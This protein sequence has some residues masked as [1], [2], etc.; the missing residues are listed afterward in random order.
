M[1]TSGVGQALASEQRTS[2][3]SR[4]VI[5]GPAGALLRSPTRRSPRP[6]L[7][8]AISAAYINLS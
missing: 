8:N 3:A 5:G 7:A 6:S 1:K 2:A 4:A